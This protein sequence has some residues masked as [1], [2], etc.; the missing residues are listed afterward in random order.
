MRTCL[1]KYVWM[2]FLYCAMFAGCGI[3]SRCLSNVDE[4]CSLFVGVWGD[5]FSSSGKGYLDCLL[6]KQRTECLSCLGVV[7][8]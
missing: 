6:L 2:C 1:V 5:D 3:S 4:E 7:L 8:L